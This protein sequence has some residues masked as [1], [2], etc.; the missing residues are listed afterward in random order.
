MVFSENGVRYP[1][2]TPFV[3][4]ESIAA[5]VVL[6]FNGAVRVI[7]FLGTPG[8]MAEARYCPICEGAT[9]AEVCPKDGVPTI[10]REVVEQGEAVDPLVGEVFAKRFRID[11]VLG[12]GGFGTV[13]SSTQLSMSRKAAVKTLRAE[14]GKDKAQLK[15]FY[16]E[17]RAAS[18]LTSPHVVR[19]YDFGIDDERKTPFIAMEHLQGRD[20]SAA[21]SSEAP[22][23]P[24][25]AAGILSQVAEALIE[26]AEMGIVHRDLKP[27]NIFLMERAGRGE[28]VKVM[29]FGIAKVI[30]TDSSLQE[31]LTGTGMTIGTPKY[32]SPE[33]A[34]SEPLDPRS[35]LYSLGCILYEMLT[36]RLLFEAPD[37]LGA[38]MMRVTDEPPGLPDPLPDGTPLPRALAVLHSRLV[39]RQRGDRPSGPSPVAQ[40][41]E[42]ISL[43][44][45]IDADNLL[46]PI[47]GTPAAASSKT[48]P[49]IPSARPPTPTPVFMASAPR[50]DS[51]FNET[52]AQTPSASLHAAQP[53][54]PAGQAAVAVGDPSG[55]TDISEIQS[56]SVGSPFDRTSG[57]LHDRPPNHQH[58]QLRPRRGAA[59]S[60]A[61]NGQGTP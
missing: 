35:D 45:E 41:L 50:S 5:R 12:Q 3:F 37:T 21:I 31:S 16:H 33:Q 30:R 13:Y 27:D 20:L 39:A 48:A 11:A 34:M 8:D 7:A 44:E 15:R 25:R 36:G 4:D 19:I 23:P 51:A 52:M 43:G 2:L 22:M 53:P 32:M 54:A 49:A 40:V 46:N 55:E 47:Y 61:G 17:A 60:G 9:D 59:R 18:A 1:H 6:R 28:F 10:L 58:L 57:S 24:R 26:A 29:D 56:L 42:A 38:L 14:L